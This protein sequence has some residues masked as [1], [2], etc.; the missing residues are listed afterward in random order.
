MRGSVARV[1]PVDVVSRERRSCRSTVE[2]GTR[3]RRRWCHWGRV[4]EVSPACR[5]GCLV[6]AARRQTDWCP[7]PLRSGP[8]LRERALGCRLVDVDLGRPD[9][10]VSRRHTGAGDRTGLDHVPTFRQV[11]E[12]ERRLGSHGVDRRA[13]RRSVSGHRVA[14]DSGFRDQGAECQLHRLRQRL[15]LLRVHPPVPMRRGRKAR[16]RSGRTS[17]ARGPMPCR[18]WRSRPRPRATRARGSRPA[19]GS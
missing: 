10:R 15:R 3:C 16:A 13:W 2:R 8:A 11:G 9:V 6:H 12:R 17:G 7:L 5:T 18:G 19:A 4:L 1:D 14:L